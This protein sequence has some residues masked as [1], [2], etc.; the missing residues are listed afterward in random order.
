M[1]FLENFNKLFE[2]K[3]NYQLFHKTASLKEILN[4]GYIYAGGKNK[5]SYPWWNFDVRKNVIPN[6]EKISL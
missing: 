1:K 4:D 6:W 3:N 5:D 2:R